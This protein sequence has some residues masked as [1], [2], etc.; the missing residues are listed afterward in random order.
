[1]L[2]L[3]TLFMLVYTAAFGQSSRVRE[4]LED[5]PALSKDIA[6][7]VYLIFA[8]RI[9]EQ[10]LE[11]QTQRQACIEDLPQKAD[12]K[13]AFTAMIEDGV[14]ALEDFDKYQSQFYIEKAK[15]PKG[16][17]VFSGGDLAFELN[18]D[19]V[20]RVS[21]DIKKVPYKAT[22]EGPN[23]PFHTRLM[24]NKTYEGK[25][26]IN[27]A[28]TSYYIFTDRMEVEDAFDI[29]N[30]EGVQEATL[31][32]KSR[33]YGFKNIPFYGFGLQD[34]YRMKFVFDE[35]INRYIELDQF[36]EGFSQA[37]IQ[38]APGVIWENQKVEAIDFNTVRVTIPGRGDLYLRAQ[39]KDLITTSRDGVH[40]NRGSAKL[41][42]S[43]LIKD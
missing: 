41:E 35:Y 37:T 23:E 1:M 11:D 28:Q 24:I 36:N 18:E 33:R 39:S 34:R 16:I 25:Y 43:T 4:M 31:L 9:C 26:K 7:A 38:N 2:K 3:L 19:Q 42:S 32:D 13:Q 27:I 22:I 20:L 8:L 30:A 15:L 17:K 5:K 12:L 14:I 29:E 21:Y 10:E 6:Q 40:F